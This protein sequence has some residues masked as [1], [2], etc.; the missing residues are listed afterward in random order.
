MRRHSSA[1]WLA[2]L[3]LG[4]GS[5]LVLGGACG[6]DGGTPTPDGGLTGGSGGS[7]GTGGGGSGGR[8]AGGGGGGGGSGGSAGDAAAVMCPTQGALAAPSVPAALQPPAGAML[9]SRTYAVGSQI[10]VCQVTMGVPAWTLK[11]PDANLYDDACALK[12]THGAGPFWKWT[13]DGSQVIGMRAA[14]APSPSGA[15]AAIPWLLLRATSNTPGYFGEVSYVQRVATTGGV[16]PAAGCD[17]AAA[18]RETAVAYTAVYYFW[19]GG[20]A[21]APDAGASPDSSTGG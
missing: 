20:A 15:A 13:A 11:A 12:G 1:R 19:K 3:A 18:G 6:D 10:Y 16:A 21:P 14:D 9:F 4:A 2:V 7:G 5:A 8:D 17:A